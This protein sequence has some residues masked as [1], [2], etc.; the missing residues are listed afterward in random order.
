MKNS[1]CALQPRQISCRAMAEISRIPKKSCF[2]VDAGAKKFR[3][4]VSPLNRP[5]VTLARNGPE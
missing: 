1:A 4:G 5:Y 2:R 3:F